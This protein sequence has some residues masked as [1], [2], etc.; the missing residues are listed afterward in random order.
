MLVFFHAFIGAWAHQPEEKTGIGKAKFTKHFNLS[1][2]G[3][4]EKGEFSIEILTDDREYKIGKDVIGIVVHDKNDDDVE[5]A[6]IKISYKD[7]KEPPAIE[8]K[9]DG[10]YVVS[11]LNIKKE[12][13][14]ALNISVKKK[15]KEDSAIFI[16]PDSLN[17]LLPSGKYDMDSVKT[18]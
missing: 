15:K 8:E 7:M 12:G 13:K 10:L 3:I 5:S 11:N 2:F 18:R 16:F 4:T 17:K 6:G 9:G 14:W 1:I